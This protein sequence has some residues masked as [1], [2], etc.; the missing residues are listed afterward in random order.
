V[1]LG[2]VSSAVSVVVPSELTMKRAWPGLGSGSGFGTSGAGG[3]GGGGVP[4]PP[5][6]P[7]VAVVGSGVGGWAALVKG[8]WAWL[9][10]PLASWPEAVSPF[11]P[12]VAV[13]PLVCSPSFSS[14]CRSLWVGSVMVERP[15][16]SCGL[17]IACG[18]LD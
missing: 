17:V 5:L 16:M 1:T 6:P 3:A 10:L 8:S 13:A 15:R 11:S 18:G 7:P 12:G 9:V 14:S 4:M 2:P